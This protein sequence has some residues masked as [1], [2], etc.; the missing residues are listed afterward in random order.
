MAVQ[1]LLAIVERCLVLDT[2]DELQPPILDDR[3]DLPGQHDVFFLFHGDVYVDAVYVV[4]IRLVLLTL[5]DLVLLD[6]D[7][8]LVVD[9]NAV[10]SLCHD[11]DVLDDD[12]SHSHCRRQS[13][14]Y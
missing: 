8:D 10:L 3:L 5:D 7:D 9:H 4:D 13:P 1:G 14:D 11:V 12:Y 2:V 6:D